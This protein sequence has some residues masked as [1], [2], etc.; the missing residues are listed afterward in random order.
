MPKYNNILVPVSFEAGRNAAQ[1]L[2][3]ADAIRASGGRIT[4]LHVLEQ[5][6]QY[7][8][9]QLPADHID[10]ARA[11]VSGKLAP[12][13]ENLPDAELVVVEGHSARSILDYAEEHA[14]DCIVLAGHRPGMQDLLLGSTAARVVRQ[15]S[16][17]VHVVR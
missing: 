11:T 15:A 6:P 8:S 4:V 13:T 2:E 14:K 17:S 7:A 1:A 5:L 9:D 12:L 3:I 16:C 10:A